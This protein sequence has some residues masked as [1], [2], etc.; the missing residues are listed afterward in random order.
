MNVAVKPAR[1]TTPPAT[2]SLAAAPIDRAHFYAPDSFWYRSLPA[3]VPLHPSTDTWRR[4]LCAQM[5]VS[6]TT[7]QTLHHIGGYAWM[8]PLAG[9]YVVPAGYPTQPVALRSEVGLSP[10][11]QGVDAPQLQA[12]LQ[13]GVPLPP[14]WA[15]SSSGDR[16]VNV[17]Q[18]AT[19]TVWEIIGTVHN[20][21]YGVVCDYGGVA[22]RVS[23]NPGYYQ[24]R[25]G[26]DGRAWQN[27]MWG[28]GAASISLLAGMLQPEE[29]AAGFVGHAL[30]MSVGH[31]GMPWVFPA[32]R[33]DGWYDRGYPPEGA[34]FRFPAD[35]DVD[36]A[37]ARFHADNAMTSAQLAQARA[38]V[39]LMVETIRDY[40]VVVDDQTGIGCQIKF[41]DYA[42]VGA[43]SVWPSVLPWYPLVQPNEY[44]WA[45]PWHLAQVID[46]AFNT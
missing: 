17:Y 42:S 24:D 41:R 3:D 7:G 18:P 27:H 25:Y 30:S 39:R 31:A 40:G 22:L 33:G 23:Q 5:D 4:S 36:A 34:R 2:S 44:M 29:V 32:Q 8:G 11:L 10:P 45:L 43:G 9:V 20:A 26:I 1:A 35:V 12:L 6:D 19:D 37:V 15:A 38:F 16:S 13:A 14:D 28:H 21:T 46:P